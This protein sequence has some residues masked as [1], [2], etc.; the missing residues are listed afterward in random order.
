MIIAVNYCCYMLL[1]IPWEIASYYGNFSHRV[2]AEKLSQMSRS[3]EMLMVD[4]ASELGFTCTNCYQSEDVSRKVCAKGAM[5]L[6]VRTGFSVLLC[7]L[8]VQR[9]KVAEHSF[10]ACPAVFIADA[11]QRADNDYQDETWRQ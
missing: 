8:Q 6:C 5:N 11:R 9:F 1:S 4:L 10:C 3:G 7:S 2:S